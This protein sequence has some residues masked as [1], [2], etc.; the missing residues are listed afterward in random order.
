MRK[1][2]NE[3]IIPMINE[4]MLSM[5][6]I[7]ELIEIKEFVDSLS[8]KKY[9]ERRTVEDINKKY[10][11]TPSI[12]TWG[13]YFQTELASSLVNH[14]DEDFSAAVETIKFDIISSYIIFSEQTPDFFE[15]VDNKYYELITLGKEEQ[16]EDDKEI[17][18]LKIL[19]DYY[20]DMGIVNNFNE[21]TMRWYNSFKE[22]M[23][24]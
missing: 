17:R 15:W 6:R 24:I 19:K 22:A 1:I 3:A 21:S 20:V 18:H 7:K 8:T 4:G 9:I 12:I 13:D 2:I 23:A 10:G 5:N 14:S 11:V 16:S